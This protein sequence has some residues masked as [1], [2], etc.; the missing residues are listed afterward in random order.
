MIRTA[1]LKL[2][3]SLSQ[4]G[5]SRFTGRHLLARQNVA[6]SNSLISPSSP[7]DCS[8]RYRLPVC[9][10]CGPLTL[11]ALPY[12]SPPFDSTHHWQAPALA[13]QALIAFCPGRLSCAGLRQRQQ[14]AEQVGEQAYGR[15]GTQSYPQAQQQETQN[16]DNRQIVK[17]LR[18]RRCFCVPQ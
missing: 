6:G 11:V 10:V 8:L 3:A 9:F 15:L 5:S 14:I 1:P 17:W 2:C 13:S 4:H 12:K 16:E 7:P 18:R